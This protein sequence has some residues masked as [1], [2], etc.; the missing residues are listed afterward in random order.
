MLLLD[1]S[2]LNGSC[3]EVTS[4]QSIDQDRLS[5]NAYQGTQLYSAAQSQDSIH[6]VMSW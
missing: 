4:W 1:Q 2:R 3:Q 6:V 5:P